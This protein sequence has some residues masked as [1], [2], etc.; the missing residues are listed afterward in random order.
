MEIAVGLIATV[1]S[2]FAGWWLGKRDTERTQ[3][4]LGALMRAEEE[5]G[6]QVTFTWDKKG[7][8][9]ALLRKRDL[10]GHMPAPHGDLQATV[11]RRTEEAE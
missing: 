4:M 2:L 9:T 8:P 5:R 10:A 11:T 3:W 1:A 7:L 6:T